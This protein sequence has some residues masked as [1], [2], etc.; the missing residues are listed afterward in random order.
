[1]EFQM[2]ISD[3]TFWKAR[4][5]LAAQ[6]NTD[7]GTLECLVWAQVLK[8]AGLWN[9]E[10]PRDLPGKVLVKIRDL[11][12]NPGAL[13]FGVNSVVQPEMYGQKGQEEPKDSDPFAEGNYDD[14]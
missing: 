4:C 10:T 2:L 11:Q 9:P 1:M 12:L 3:M 8:D 6:L 14:R 13:K 7:V 5:D